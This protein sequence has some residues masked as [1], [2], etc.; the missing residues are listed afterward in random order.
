MNSSTNNI[1]EELWY[2]NIDP[3]N[4]GIFLAVI[5]Y[6]FILTK[7]NFTVIIKLRKKVEIQN[8]SARY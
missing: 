7:D 6:L 3:L 4:G 2:G 8:N 5:L 1:I